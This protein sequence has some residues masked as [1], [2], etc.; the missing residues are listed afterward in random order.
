[1]ISFPT[2]EWPWGQTG[3]VGYPDRLVRTWRRIDIEVVGGRRLAVV[4]GDFFRYFQVQPAFWNIE[5]L[6]SAC[7]AALASGITD[8]WAFEAM[9]LDGA[10]Q[11]YVAD[12][13]WPNVH[14]GFIAAGSINP[15]AI[16][17]MSRKAAP[18]LHAQ[19]VRD[20]IGINN[21]AIYQLYRLCRRGA[22]LLRHPVRALVFR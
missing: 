13:S 8:P 5:Y 6:T 15:A 18:E 21:A 19:L 16:S 14:H 22:G 20:V 10:R 12:Y 3:C 1:M 11:H 2:Y 9:R 7:R 17:Y 4:P